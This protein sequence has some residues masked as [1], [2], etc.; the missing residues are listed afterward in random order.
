[1]NHS[2]AGGESSDH[3]RRSPLVRN[4]VVSPAWT[5]CESGGIGHPRKRANWLPLPVPVLFLRSAECQATPA[6][7]LR[8]NRPRGCPVRRPRTLTCPEHAEGCLASLPSGQAIVR[9]RLPAAVRAGIVA[10][11]IGGHEAMTARDRQ[12]H[13]A[14]KY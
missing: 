8:G 3:V 14:A 5:H 7:L 12:H 11:G 10:M 4:V 2:A 13:G 6:T 9:D 1:M